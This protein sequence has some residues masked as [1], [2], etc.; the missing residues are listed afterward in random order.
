MGI[1]QTPR[2]D[3]RYVTELWPST[4]TIYCCV[5]GADPSRFSTFSFFP[6]SNLISIVPLINGKKINFILVKKL[7]ELFELYIWRIIKKIHNENKVLNVAL[8]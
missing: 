7:A 4:W 6:Q 3:D 2:K 5:K 8:C 1:G